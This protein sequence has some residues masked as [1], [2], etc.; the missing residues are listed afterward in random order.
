ME[1]KK[2]K[3]DRAYVVKVGLSYPT[4]DGEKQATPGDTITDLPAKSVSWLT[5]EGYIV[6]AKEA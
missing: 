3:P 5:A 2:P 6:P 1:S 4:A